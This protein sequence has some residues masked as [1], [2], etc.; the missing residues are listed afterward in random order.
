MVKKY[1][2]YLKHAP[3][4]LL[5]MFTRERLLGPALL[6]LAERDTNDNTDSRYQSELQRKLA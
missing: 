2:Y 3:T 4:K 1:N 6:F 5:D